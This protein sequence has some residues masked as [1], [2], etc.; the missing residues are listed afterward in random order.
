MKKLLQL[1]LLFA[2]LTLCAEAKELALIGDDKICVLLTVELSKDDDLQL[3]ERAEID[4]V[5]KEHKLSEN[6]LAATQLVKLFP[7]VDIFAVVRDKR[8]IVFNAQNGFRL[9]DANTAK[10]QEI[11]KVDPAGGEKTLS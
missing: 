6:K 11:T 3:L 8:L 7:H 5:L 1:I 2:G 4:K 9:M 10:V